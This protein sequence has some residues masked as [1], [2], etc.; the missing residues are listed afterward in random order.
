MVTI[1]YYKT[2]HFLNQTSPHT[3]PKQLLQ[4]S[5][6]QGG[7]FLYSFFCSVAARDR[8]LTER[9]SSHV[10]TDEMC[11]LHMVSSFSLKFKMRS[12]VIHGDLRGEF[13]LLRFH[14]SQLRWLGHLNKC[15]PP[16]EGFLG[17]S[18]TRRR[19]WVR[20]GVYVS[21]LVWE[22]LGIPQEGAAKY[23]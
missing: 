19:W 21:S 3:H 22:R 11:F 18:F 12:S 8:I 17:M 20:P 1:F 15:A 4:L 23:L 10:Q 7:G 6:L 5:P 13:L 9:T 2:R 16:F 14:R